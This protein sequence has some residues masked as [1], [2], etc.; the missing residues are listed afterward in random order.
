MNKIERKTLAITVL[1]I[2][3]CATV[4]AGFAT[5]FA[6]ETV[7]TLDT[8]TTT[9]SPTT[10]IAD[11]I[12]TSTDIATLDMQ[13]LVINIGFPFLEGEM[14]IGDQGFGG[15]RIHGG[16]GM[17][18]AA[19]RNI[20]ISSDYVSTVNNILNNDTD[21]Q[22]LVSQGFN[23]TAIRPMVKNVIGAD[24]T[25]STSA[26]TAIV[27]MQNGTSGHATVSVDI[28]NAKVTQIVILTRTV[29]DKLTS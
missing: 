19:P 29:I 10:S 23:V 25:I 7:T 16:R 11:S 21:V 27:I 12:T 26:A 5:T 9:T 15:L 3:A 24:G 6:E 17:G 18:F 20:E 13:N 8:S 22:N 28:T 14:I 4:F 1:L 2:V